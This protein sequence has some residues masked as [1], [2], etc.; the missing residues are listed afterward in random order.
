MQNI[1]PFQFGAA[2]DFSPEKVLDY[3]IED[4]NYS[5]F[6][7]S[8]RNVIILGERGSGKTMTLLYHN[9]ATQRCKA[10][11]SGV[12]CSLDYIGV[13]VP[14][15]TPL[16]HRK[17]Y[18]L[19]TDFKAE[20]LSEHFLTLGIVHWLAKTLDENC[21]VIG[22][23]DTAALRD[24]LG[25]AI[26]RDLPDGRSF[27]K[28][29]LAFTRHEIR[30]T[31]RTINQAD[32]DA[33]YKQALSFVTLLMPLF[34][35]LRQIS[36]LSASHFL[37]MIDDAHDLNEHQMRLINSWIAYRD[38]SLFSIKIATVKVH[39][40]SLITSTGGSILEGHDFTVVDMEKPF[41]NEQSDFGQLARRIVAR[42]LARIGLDKTPE[43]FFP[44]HKSVE[45]GLEAARRTARE[46]ARSKFRDGTETQISDYVYKYHRAIYFRRSKRANLPVYS[47]F[48]TIVYISTGV[49]RN[50]LEPCYWMYDKA[51]SSS[52]HLGDGD[53]VLE[54]VSPT[55]QNEV[56]MDHS[57]RAWERIRD[58]LDK[59]VVNCSEEDAK[60]IA[61]FFEAIARLFRSRLFSNA[62]EPRATSFSVSERDNEPAMKELERLLD[63]ARKAT[64][65]YARE[66]AAKDHGSREYYYVP[67]RI[68]WPIRGL[69]TQGQHARVQLRA[70]R[71][72]ATARGRGG[73]TSAT[74][75]AAGENLQRELF[76]G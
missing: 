23:M 5:R 64:L 74:P 13:Y 60:A 51:V 39:R 6:I 61:R 54:S 1:N 62:S 41:Q 75:G 21:E 34:E 18:E 24:D 8:K 15:N 40:P 65:L 14:C 3:Y 47:G 57:A 32:S 30:E 50:L 7:H 45:E 10:A 12:L 38:H 11:R 59:I 31:Q 27:F 48:K 53:A 58:G 43:E 16:M 46:E 33:F 26:G 17:E 36:A 28:Q 55:V 20:V 49:V 67:N 73:L 2:N 63:I 9:L 44:V 35:L 72:L 22:E 68:L 37:L 19:L 66:G 52:A 29:L 70:S 69:D 71:L 4:F 76:N 56:I 25:Y 42:R